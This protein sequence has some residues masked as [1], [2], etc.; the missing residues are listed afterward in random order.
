MLRGG[1]EDIRPRPHMESIHTAS[2]RGT[3]RMRRCWSAPSAPNLLLELARADLISYKSS[4]FPT[5][6]AP[7]W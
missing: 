6:F 2:T 5:F 4:S 3:P 7:L 1:C